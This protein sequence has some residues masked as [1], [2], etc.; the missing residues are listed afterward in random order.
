MKVLTIGDRFISQA[1][2][3]DALRP[4][5][6]AAGQTVEFVGFDL[7]WPIEPLHEG[8]EVTEFVGSAS[9]V[10]ALIGDVD[11][12]VTQMAPVTASALEKARR[13]R[14][15]ACAR[16]GPVN[17]NV[18]KATELGIPVVATAGRNARAVAE[19]TVGLMLAEVRGIARAHADLHRGT[20]RGDLYTYEK[21]GRELAELTVG[22]VG[23][24]HIG[25]LVA[26]LLRPWGCRI[27]AF[28][29]YQHW[30]E[31]EVGV[32]ALD[33]PELLRQADIVSLHARLTPE[34]K[35][36]I[37]RQEI[38]RMKKGAVLINTARGGLLDYEALYDAL[39]A[40]KLGGAALDTFDV[41]PPEVGSRLFRLGNVTVTPHIAGATRETAR[42][43][44]RMLAEEIGGFVAGRGLTHCVNPETLT[45]SPRSASR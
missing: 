9:D 43:T 16:G 21:A 44:A 24:G 18:K 1:M 27:L 13:L 28:D 45:G 30:N 31:E 41:E 10:E 29:P 14:L 33:L 38:A 23:F 19:F 32:A 37:G 15:V 17:I 4:S 34:T 22:L 6:E 5:L 40:G 42:R 8:S 39:E 35:G 20:W 7:D 11:I 12:L 25:R 2:L 26:E 3:Q 36:L